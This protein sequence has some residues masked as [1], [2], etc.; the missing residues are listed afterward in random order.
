MVFKVNWVH[1]LAGVDTMGD[2]DDGPASSKSEPGRRRPRGGGFGSSRRPGSPSSSRGGNRRPV[3]S[4]IGL[5]G[6]GAARV[7]PR[8]A[9]SDAERAAARFRVKRNF[10]EVLRSSPSSPSSAARG[11]RGGAQGGRV[12]AGGG[13]GGGCGAGGAGVTRAGRGSPDEERRRSA[14]V[15][16]AANGIPP[17][18]H[19]LDR[20]RRMGVL[21]TGVLGDTRDRYRQVQ[22]TESRVRF[23]LCGCCAW[24]GCCVVWVVLWTLS[25]YVHLTYIYPCYTPLLPSPPSPSLFSSP[26]VPSRLLPAADGCVVARAGGHEQRFTCVHPR[27]RGRRAG[28]AHQPGDADQTATEPW[29]CLCD[30]HPPHAKAA[31]E[32]RGAHQAVQNGHRGVPGGS[33]GAVFCARCVRVWGQ[34]PILCV[35]VCE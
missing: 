27:E 31:G 1:V 17:M 9:A 10:P 20:S 21:A 22:I 4:P 23:L 30:Q 11:G 18:A 15:N 5:G 33:G 26:P 29:P 7:R 25:C 6:R 32:H 13:G 16:R 28:G 24:C 2:G 35:C 19:T 12:G 14:A 3:S 8:S 34:G